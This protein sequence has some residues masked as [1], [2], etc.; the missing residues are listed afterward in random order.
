M[1]ND[2]SKRQTYAVSPLELL[3]DLVIVFACSE[4]TKHLLENFS[5]LGLVEIMILLIAVYN[6]WTYT[7]FGATLIQ[8]GNVHSRWLLMIVMLLGIFMN[9]GIDESFGDHAWIFVLPYL[10]SQLGQGLFIMI[11]S[12]NKGLRNHYRVLTIWNLVTAP[13]WIAGIMVGYHLR[14]IIWSAA[15]LVDLIGLLLAHPAPGKRRSTENIQFDAVHVLER[16]RLFL[17][18]ALGEAVFSL[19]EA[20]IESPKNHITLLLGIA[21]FL[22][23]ISMWAIYFWGSDHLVVRHIEETQNPIR[24][25]HLTMNSLFVALAGLILFSVGTRMIIENPIRYHSAILNGIFF[26]GPIL[27]LV[28]HGWYTWYVLKQVPFVR[29]T[30][31]ILLALGGVISLHWPSYLALVIIMVFMVTLTSIIII[32]NKDKTQAV[33]ES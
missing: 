12:K 20:M 33:G 1:N 28:S 25:A 4:L 11:F 23:I 27:Y 13:L 22:T 29:I 26:G 17:I 6:L 10:S 5:W 3:F 9:T 30:F 31:C 19:I 15:A 18:I 21:S 2:I 7:S 16:C 32:L 24:T 8:S 14:I